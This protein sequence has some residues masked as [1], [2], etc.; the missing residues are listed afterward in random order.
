MLL[1]FEVKDVETK[2]EEGVLSELE[3]ARALEA[4]AAFSLCSS[5]FFLSS[6][7][8]TTPKTIAIAITKNATAAT[9]VQNQRL[10]RYHR[11]GRCSSG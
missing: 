7:L 4:S 3:C 1:D 5:F 8:S 11:T 2:D 6:S 9:M 10:R